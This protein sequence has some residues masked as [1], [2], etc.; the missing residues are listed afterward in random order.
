M[1]LLRLFTVS[2]YFHSALTKLDYSF[3]HT[4]GQQFLQALVSPLGGRLDAWSDP[5]RLAAA[6]MFPVGELLVALA[7][8][9]ARTR[10]IGLV[11]AIVLHLLLL[12]ILGP[13]GLDHR[14]GVLAWNAYFIVQDVLLFAPVR[15]GGDPTAA[16][17]TV[18]AA[19]AQAPWLLQAVMLAAVVLPFLEP[20]AW[21]DLWP[22]LGLYAASAQR[23]TLLVHRREGGT[24][25]KELRPYIEE[26]AD[27]ADPW[28]TVRLDRW[29]LA[30]LGAPIYPQSRSQLGVAEAAIAR[31]NLGHRARVVRLDLADRWTGKRTHEVFT[32]LP[33]L[34]DAGQQY[35][36]NT[37]PRR[38][39][40]ERPRE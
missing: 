20:T 34:L 27:P 24:I 37:R 38:Q 25:G 6:A 17:N 31:F 3:L 40:F 26:P 12:W 5:W 35:Y 1:A 8:L 32:G 13:W 10:S 30:A 22:S 11:G 19:D 7:L 2:F 29:A 16:S 39:T 15:R 21:F 33:Q 28:L 14:P 18:V 36:F 9:F 23:V 4:L